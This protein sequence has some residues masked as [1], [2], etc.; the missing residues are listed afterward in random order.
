[1]G[2][3]VDPNPGQEAEFY[4]GEVNYKVE[5]KRLGIAMLETDYRP[6]FVML[7][8]AGHLGFI[9]FLY[10]MSMVEEP[11]VLA[12]DDIR[13]LKHWRSFEW[14]AKHDQFK[15][16]DYDLEERHGFCIAEWRPL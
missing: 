4:L 1:M 11:F 6:Q 16:I 8:S 12:L 3:D 5:D 2:M 7:D 15:I 14:L 13:H 10:L 9:E